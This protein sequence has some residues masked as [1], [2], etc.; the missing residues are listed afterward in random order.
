MNKVAQKSEI[1][2]GL[3]VHASTIAIA[4]SEGRDVV[5]FV[6]T[7]PNESESISKVVKR[8]LRQYE[9][10]PL[11]ACY[12]AGPCGYRLYRQLSKLGVRCVVVA[13]TLIPVRVGDRVKTDK[14]DAEKLARYFRAGDLTAVWVPNEEHEALRDLLRARESALGDLLRSKH[15][16]SKFL[17]RHGVSSPFKAWTHRYMQWIET[18]RGVG[19]I[20][21]MT[22]VSEVGQLS[23][24]DS[25]KQLMAYGGLVPREHS[26]GASIRKGSI[27]KTGNS[28][29]R[30][31]LGE[32]AFHYRFK[33]TLYPNL[34]KRQQ[35]QPK[36]IT[37][38]AW[39]AQHRLH[40]KHFKM[41]LKGKPKGQV[42]SAVSRELIGFIW[43]IG[44]RIERMAT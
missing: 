39:K 41:T 21:A 18:L 11:H 22:V 37:D 42:L 30:R 40:N 16:L 31:V 34:R 26:S 20:T 13:P 3:D 29:L 25:P 9:G 15:R 2:V 5:R 4:V 7:I 28:H 23:R 33:P 38:I 14:R 12:E 35:G 1:Y 10:H 43:D 24:F 19:K 44:Q 17:L 8:L 36:A 6:G 27:T 32:S